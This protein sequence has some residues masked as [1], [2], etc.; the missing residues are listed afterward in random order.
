MSDSEGEELNELDWAF[1][2]ALDYNNLES[3]YDLLDE[4]ANINARNEYGE[5]ILDIFLRNYN[6]DIMKMMLTKG[7]DFQ[8]IDNGVHPPSLGYKIISYVMDAIGQTGPGLLNIVMRYAPFNINE[9]DRNGYT[10]LHKAITEN[11]DN[12]HAEGFIKT[13]LDHGADINAQVSNTGNTVL[14]FVAQEMMDYTIFN[15]MRRVILLL[16]SYGADIS[17][18]NASGQRAQDI[19]PGIVD[20]YNQYFGQ[21][22]DT[23]RG[24]LEVGS[25]M[26]GN[27]NQNIYSYLYRH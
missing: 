23:R 5:G 16:L 3:A 13:L 19:N 17:I 2:E 27:L 25:R 22:A 18:R 4:G 21:R 9:T 24:I 26:P 14:M 11:R 7:Y 20:I 8:E 6:I 1:H 12:L 15:E 10:L